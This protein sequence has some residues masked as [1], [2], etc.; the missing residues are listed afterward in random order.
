MQLERVFRAAAAASL[1]VAAPLFAQDTTSATPARDS[2]LG[3]KP[4]TTRTVLYDSTVLR[5]L[6]IDDVLD[7][8]VLVPGIYGLTNPRAFSVRGGL[9]GDGAIYV[10]GA[11]IRNG[12]R[13]GAELLPPLWGIQSLAVTTGLAPADRGDFRLGSLEIVTPTGGREWTVRFGG[14]ADRLGNKEF[15]FDPWRNVGFNR[16]VVRASGGL[17]AGLTAFVAV[18]A[19]WQE[20]LETEKLRDVQA[21][22]YVASG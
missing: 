6:P 4:P 3:R 15:P 1:A 8:P 17:P 18:Q 20:S 7:V 11:L 5:R 13:Q 9:N 22:V 21:P 14:G 10:D 19:D 12:Q 2:S 16:L